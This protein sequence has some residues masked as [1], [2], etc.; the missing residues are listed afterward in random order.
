MATDPYRAYN[1]NLLIEGFPSAGFTEVSGL[2]AEIETIAYREA[3]AGTTV[4]HLPGQLRLSPM[5]LRF[6]VTHERGLWDWF[7]ETAAGNVVRRNV[8]VIQLGNDRQSEAFRWNLHQAWPSSFSA[9]PMTGLTSEIAIEKLTLVY[10][11]LER[12]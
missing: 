10:D 5:E 3:G 11:R 1:F 8:S 6:G 12:D 9:A 2:G 4:R 7:Q